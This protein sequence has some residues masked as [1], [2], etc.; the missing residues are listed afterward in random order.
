[1]Y[2]IIVEDSFSA[3]HSLKLYDGSHEP[4][5]GHDFKVA[6]LMR[7]KMLDSMGVV[8]DFEALKPC[9]KNILAELDEIFVNEHASFRNGKLNPSVENI[10]KWI[11]DELTKKFKAPNAK[12]AKVTV[13]ETP[14][15]SGSYTA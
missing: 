10:A 7:A 12:I 4:R 5:H 8:A 14:D 13:W 15:A 1:M 9:L 3:A 6:V 11:Y 2:E